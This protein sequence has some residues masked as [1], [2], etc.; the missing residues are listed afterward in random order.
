M[1]LTV[2]DVMEYLNVSEKTVYTWIKKRGLPAHRVSG[3]YR[4]SRVEL[5]EWATSQQVKVAP[6]IFNH[7]QEAAEL[8]PDFVAALERGGIHYKVPDTSKERALHALVSVMP[9]PAG[10]DRQL[11]LHLLLAREALASTAVGDGIAIPHARSPI[12]LHVPNPLITLC[13]LEKPVDFGALDGQPVG[14]L[15]S[16]VTPTM[17]A[18]LHLLSRLSFALHDAA[19]RKVVSNQASPEEIL[20]EARR[21]EASL[22]R[23]GVPSNNVAP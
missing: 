6:E 13:F 17:R 1:Q 11:L 8:L 4:F 18:H 16:L 19:F 12:V 23:M 9:L 10:V 5:L 3:Q 21:V 20:K 2:R 14:I 15:F 7:L 22:G